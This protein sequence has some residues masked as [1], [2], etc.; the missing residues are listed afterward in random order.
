MNLEL[1]KETIWS[2]QD[3]NYQPEYSVKLNG[4]YMYVGANLDKAK[5]LYDKIKSN[6]QAP[7]K[8]ILFQ[9]TLK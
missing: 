2:T 5:S 6:Y 4:K 7:T 1:I 9:T 3:E 8:E